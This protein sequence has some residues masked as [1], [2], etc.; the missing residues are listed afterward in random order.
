MDVFYQELVKMRVGNNQKDKT[1]VGLEDKQMPRVPK[2]ML[3]QQKR[4]FFF[5]NGSLAS[6]N[7]PETK[8][9]CPMFWGTQK[10]VSGESERGVNPT[11][12]HQLRQGNAFI[13]FP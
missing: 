2:E 1:E 5:Q 4:S 10:N 8:I 7:Q 13:M 3:G 12:S 9:N 6:A 11:I